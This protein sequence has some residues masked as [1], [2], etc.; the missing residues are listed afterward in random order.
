MY[1]LRANLG[2]SII[3]GSQQWEESTC[4]DSYA[5]SVLQF[6]YYYVT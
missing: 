2:K 4:S 6:D 3:N 1:Q 5:Y